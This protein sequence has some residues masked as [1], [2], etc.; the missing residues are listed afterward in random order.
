MR[1]LLVAAL[2]CGISPAAHA[3]LTCGSARV[4]VGDPG[5]GGVVSTTVARDPGNWTIKYTLANGSVADRSLQYVITDYSGANTM[6]WR[7]TQMRN[8]A[9]TMTGE[10]MTLNSTGQPTYDEWQ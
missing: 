10:L 7:G 5:R 3:A 8:P 1:S 6:Q 4:D 2:L 9:V